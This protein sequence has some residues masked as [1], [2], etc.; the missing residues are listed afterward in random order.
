MNHA[1]EFEREKAPLKQLSVSL[2][3]KQI[4]MQVTKHWLCVDLGRFGAFNVFMF[5]IF[6]HIMQGFPNVFCQPIPLKNIKYLLE[7]SQS[8]LIFQ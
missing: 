8:K 6:F 5:I 3:M 4:I 7:I 1:F 2:S